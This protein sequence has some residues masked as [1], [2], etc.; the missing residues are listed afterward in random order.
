MALPSFVQTRESLVGVILVI[1]VVTLA[2]VFGG[3]TLGIPA[4]VIGLLFIIYLHQLD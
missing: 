4:S 3:T 2:I 1:A